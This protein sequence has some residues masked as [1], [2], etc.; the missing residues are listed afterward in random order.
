MIRIIGNSGCPVEIV[1]GLND[2][3]LVRKSCDLQGSDRLARQMKKQSEFNHSVI[4]SPT[5]I[6][7]GF[8]SDRFIVEMQYIKSLDF[9]TFTGT[10]TNES[11]EKVSDIIT[12]FI[13]EEFENSSLSKF[14]TDKWESKIFDVSKKSFDQRKLK[15]SDLRQ[16]EN[17]LLTDTPNEILIG[18]CH[19]DLT[20]SNVLIGEN[21]EVVFIDFLDP[22]IESPYEDLSKILQDTTHQWSIHHYN[23]ACDKSGVKI[24]WK[25]LENM[26][27]DKLKSYVDI[28]ALKKIQVMSL[29]RI[30]PYTEKHHILGFL[31]DSISKEI[32]IASNT[33]LRR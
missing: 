28:H 10:S 17:F 12:E 7:Q 31:L 2:A 16:I 8:S 27:F 15:L 25:Y 4:K 14:P 20:L 29:F 30:V 21:D 6:K 19:G 33:T 26:M 5:V 3:P 13:K 32:S 22:P 1:Q 11:Y 18:R 9:V 24:R 23:G